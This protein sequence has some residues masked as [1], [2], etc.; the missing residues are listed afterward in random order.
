MEEAPAEEPPVGP[1]GSE[2]AERAREIA[3][4]QLAHGPRT[5]AQLR[6]VLLERGLPAEVA[7]EVLD[8]YEAVGLV[9]DTAFAEQWV[10]ERRAAHGVSRRALATEL[11]RKQVPDDIAAEALDSLADTDERAAAE[12]LVARKLPATRGLDQ[13][14]RASRLVAM[15][16]RKGYDP[17]LASE[18]VRA[19]LAEAEGE[20]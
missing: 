16:A 12:A 10:R 15:L 17:E 4:R 14:R 2:L 7:D 11:R 6:G 1:A 8:R 13:R 3:L 20:S 5:R 9:D 18:V 19:A